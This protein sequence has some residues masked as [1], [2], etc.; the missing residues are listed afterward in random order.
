[1]RI[2]CKIFGLAKIAVNSS[3]ASG[4]ATLCGVICKH[5][6]MLWPMLLVRS[7]MENILT[8]G[9][10][11]SSFCWL[12]Y[13]VEYSSSTH[14]GSW[15]GSWNIVKQR[16]GRNLVLCNHDGQHTT[17]GL[18]IYARNKNLLSLFC[19]PLF[20]SLVLYSQHNLVQTDTTYNSYDLRVILKEQ[21]WRRAYERLLH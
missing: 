10:K 13:E 3:W 11:F 15:G 7:V 17:S 18:L 14:F 8:R 19:M 4:I 5:M 6:P 20:V 21:N 16:N 12:E 9:A 1:M 2:F